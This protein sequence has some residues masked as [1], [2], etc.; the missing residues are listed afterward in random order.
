M[1]LN[2]SK[3]AIKQELRGKKY[4]NKNE[5][6]LQRVKQE[7]PEKAS[8]TYSGTTQEK[9]ENIKSTLDNKPPTTQSSPKKS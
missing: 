6:K 4:I 9:V 7:L 1:S 3:N 8:K 2:H 5:S